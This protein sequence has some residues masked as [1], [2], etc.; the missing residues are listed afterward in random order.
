MKVY[1]IITNKIIE[2][3][4][5]GVVP[6]QRPWRTTFPTNFVSKKMYRGINVLMLSMQDFDSEYWAT[7]KQ[8]RKAGGNV[9]KGSKGTPV[10]YTNWIE[11]NDEKNGEKKKIP[12]LKYYTVFNLE[13]TKGIEIPK[14][15][16]STIDKLEKCETIW[17][18]MPSKPSVKDDGGNRAYYRPITD[19]IHLPKWNKF[20]TAEEYYS[21]L[22]HELVHSTGHSS[23]LDREGITEQ[24]GFGSE[25]Y[26][27]EELIAEIG[28]AFMCGITGIEKKTLNNSTAYIQSWL[29]KLRDDKRLIVVAAAQAQKAVD[30]ITNKKETAST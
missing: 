17:K 1:E 20:Q 23:R 3:L 26:S 19:S 8:I 28:S 21:T 24:N 6:W 15:E 29:H 11:V 27:K 9:K 22:Y 12:F 18:E 14:T 25:N 30:Y 10:V 2:Q 5:N 16:A 7:F 4:E 13:Q